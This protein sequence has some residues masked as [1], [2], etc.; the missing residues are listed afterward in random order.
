MRYVELG[1]DAPLMGLDL[2]ELH[3]FPGSGGE[4]LDAWL[5]ASSIDG[6]LA[7][8]ALEAR[9]TL[10][11][12]WLPE[13]DVRE[14]VAWLHLVREPN[15]GRL[16]ADVRE[17]LAS[18]ERQKIPGCVIAYLRERAHALLRDTVTDRVT[19]SDAIFG[20]LLGASLQLEGEAVCLGD[21]LSLPVSEVFDA[22]S[23]NAFGLSSLRDLM[24]DGGNAF[25]AHMAK[26]PGRYLAQL[27]SDAARSI[28]SDD[29]L[30]S[31]ASL[32]ERFPS[33]RG[34][35][36]TLERIVVA[37]TRRERLSP[38]RRHP[39]DG[40]LLEATVMSG[41]WT[42]ALLTVFAELDVLAHHDVSAYAVAATAAIRNAW[43]EHPS[44]ATYVALR[45]HRTLRIANAHHGQA[46]GIELSEALLET[47]SRLPGGD[48]VVILLDRIAE[49]AIGAPGE[50]V[51]WT[52]LEGGAKSHWGWL[53]YSALAT[54]P[55]MIDAFVRF[56]MECLPR[57]TFD[58]VEPVIIELARDAGGWN[59]VEMLASKRGGTAM[60]RAGNLLRRRR[61]G[62]LTGDYGIPG[63]ER[64]SSP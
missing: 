60:I 49:L 62:R 1:C 54:E 10:F 15:V 16:L 46:D 7:V 2:G 12:S 14:A 45:L 41:G 30:P 59:V 9:R 63:D 52:Y 23:S 32:L 40:R 6:D 42:S 34:D 56:S 4:R 55:H 17:A 58:D 25:D 48:R 64:P 47:L 51:A 22:F 35:S 21:G 8:V 18:V 20:F 24:T 36:E 11:R 26:V 44:A 33:L 43:A 13:R 61:L 37:L 39:D 29:D 5:V 53:V 38:S 31:P 19:G 3:S 57:D 27:R 28:E 50:K